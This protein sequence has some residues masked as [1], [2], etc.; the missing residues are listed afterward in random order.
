MSY[1]S[2]CHY[3]VHAKHQNLAVAHFLYNQPNNSYKLWGLTDQDNSR[4][5]E[6]QDTSD[7]WHLF[8]PQHNGTDSFSWGPGR[9]QLI[10]EESDLRSSAVPLRATLVQSTQEHHLKNDK[11]TSDEVRY[12]WVVCIN[13][14]VE[15]HKRNQRGTGKKTHI[16]L[17]PVYLSFNNKV[18]IN[19][20]VMWLTEATHQ[21]IVFVLMCL[22]RFHICSLLYSDL[23]QSIYQAQVKHTEQ[24]QTRR[25]EI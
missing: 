19:L 21:E 17:Y 5:K 1:L 22:F 4:D 24:T 25:V 9:A 23:L 13:A 7:N 20:K 12:C 6:E 8:S 15:I 3:T 16:T 18:L 11:A 14:W 10:V 2:V